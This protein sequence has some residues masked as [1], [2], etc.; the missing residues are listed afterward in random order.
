MHSKTPFL[1]LVPILT[2]ILTACPGNRVPSVSSIALDPNTTVQPCA[3]V[4]VSV[5]ASDPEGAK[6]KYAFDVVDANDTSLAPLPNASVTQNGPS[7]SFVISPS[8]S[9]NTSVR[10]RLEVSDGA[11]SITTLSQPVTLLGGAEQPC[12]SIEGQVR[13]G[14]RFAGASAGMPSDAQFVPDEA[15]VKLKPEALRPTD[16]SSRTDRIAFARPVTGASGIVRRDAARALSLNPNPETVRA[17]S[18]RGLET[19][20]WIAQLRARPDVLYAEPNLILRAQVVPNDPLYAGGATPTRSQ[21]WHYEMLNL[22]AAWDQTTGSADVTVA[23]IDTGLLWSA[24]DPAR[25]HP[26]FDCEVAPGKPKVLP[27][28]DFLN[29]DADS[30]DSDPGADYHGTHVAGTVG[31]CANNAQGGV[32]VAWG[33]RILPI[34]ALNQGGGS[35]ENIARAIYWAVGASIPASFGSGTNI[36]LNPNPANIINMSLGGRGQPSKTLQEAIDTATGRGAVVVVAAGN[37][38]VDASNFLPANQ[39]GVIAIGALGPTRA[40]ASYSNYGPIVSLMAPGGD[41]GLQRRPEDGVLSSIG[42]CPKDAD[43]VTLPGCGVSVVPNFDYGFE[44]GTSMASPHVAG[45]VALMMSAQASLRAPADPAHNWV[46]VAGLLRDA[47]S[48]S[49]LSLC[50]RGCGAGL[51]DANKAITNAVN[52]TDTGPFLVQIKDSGVAGTTYGPIDLGSS[53]TTASFAVRNEGTASATVNLSPSGPGLTVSPRQASLAPGEVLAATVTLERSTLAQGSYGS[54]ITMSYGLNRSLVMPVYYT[55][56]GPGL[57]SDTSN[58]RV[59]LYRRDYTCQSDQQRLNFPGLGVDQDGGFRFSN[60]EPGTYD[61]VAYRLRSD[62]PDGAG[63]SE[64]GRLNEIGI[65][66]S[67]L[68]VQAQ[69][70]TLETVN[71]TI[72]AE[73]PTSTRC[74]PKN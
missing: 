57:L 12:G 39:Q 17:D 25:R 7:A 15:I 33:A 66:A 72:G 11:N 52:N 13:P 43:G 74:N 9:A 28:F 55:Q 61:L 22:P 6:L 45:V 34:R 4:K 19:L 56:G 10:V 3:S 1:T 35:I 53:L 27:G 30:Y 68:Q 49:G 18:A 62:T 31:A 60:L 64:L 14:V 23:V 29:N 48:L 38:G 51:L 2:A 8:P 5:T 32:G 20:A 42:V 58:V 16:L 44:Q 59:R 40:R 26:D 54:N 73:Q 46:R 37:D 47:S 70:L 65:G 36:P 67:G 50:E 24:T 21:R 41:Q 71:L 63:V 69:D